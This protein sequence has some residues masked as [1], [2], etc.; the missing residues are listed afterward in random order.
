M[1]SRWKMVAAVLAV[2]TTVLTCAGILAVHVVRDRLVDRIDD[3]LRASAVGAVQTTRILDPEQPCF[4][5]ARERCVPGGEVRRTR[6]GVGIDATDVTK[7]GGAEWNVWRGVPRLI[8][9]VSVSASYDVRAV[10]FAV[11]GQP[12]R[13]RVEPPGADDRRAIRQ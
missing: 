7:G 3:E 9:I 11:P 2:V 4:D 8:Q 1:S 5:L 12:E 6:V 10:P 13:L